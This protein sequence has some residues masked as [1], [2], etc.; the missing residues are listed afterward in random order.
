MGAGVARCHS[1]QRRSRSLIHGRRARKNHWLIYSAATP[2][3]ADC[4]ITRAPITCA[5]RF[6][7]Q[8]S[9]CS[10]QAI[11]NNAIFRDVPGT[12]V[13]SRVVV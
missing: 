5:P 7:T 9:N 8:K 1:K 3:V 12:M 4:M 10:D 13:T 2:E 11:D 6:L